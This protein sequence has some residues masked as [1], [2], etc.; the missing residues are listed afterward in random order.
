MLEVEGIFIHW[1][2]VEESKFASQLSDIRPLDVWDT[3]RKRFLVSHALKALGEDILGVPPEEEALL[4][5][6][7]EA[8]GKGRLEAT[9]RNGKLTLDPL[10]V[11]L[12]GGFFDLRSE[13]AYTP[14]GISARFRANTERFDYGVLARRLDPATDM[15]GHL[16]LEAALAGLS[17]G[18]PK[19]FARASGRLD[20]A[21]WP[22]QLRSGAID[23]FSVNLF[24]AI[25]P[26]LGISES[27]VNC[28]VGRFDVVDGV[29]RPQR[30]LLDTT[31]TRVHG[32][33]TVD[34]NRERVDLI[35]RPVAKRSRL[36][37]LETPLAVDGNFSDFR[38][39][40]PPEAL[41]DSALHLSTSVV[42]APW[43]WLFEE[44]PPAD[45]ADVCA[46]PLVR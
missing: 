12:P 39:D 30:L 37:S 27:S 8:L 41:L 35:L 28:L 16:S 45:G 34:L 44:L 18:G 3:E 7:K 31:V 42:A 2:R 15:R 25:L 1:D 43:Q 23:A 9:L 11:E 46:D 20:F 19:P 29:M 26:L 13:Y 33:G 32:E 4:K 5:A 14:K 36:L 38:A 21:V 17:P 40:V 6:A 10:H 22:G 24:F